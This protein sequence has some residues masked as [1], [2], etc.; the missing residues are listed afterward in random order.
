M[1]G[2]WWLDNQGRNN[3]AGIPGSTD[4]PAILPDAIIV[5]LLV[6]IPIAKQDFKALVP[7][8]L[9]DE[10]ARLNALVAR[11]PLTLQPFPFDDQRVEDQF[12]RSQNVPGVH[13][14]NRRTKRR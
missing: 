14:P 11:N 1:A 13:D 4:N 8:M 2:N 5:E 6:A 9:P 7:M 3:L 12:M 10:Q